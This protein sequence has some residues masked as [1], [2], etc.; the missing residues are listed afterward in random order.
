MKTWTQEM[1]PLKIVKDFGPIYTTPDSIVKIRYIEFECPEC[2][3]VFKAEP[4][5]V[6]KGTVVRCSTC[7]Y[8]KNTP[9]IDAETNTKKCTSCNLK[10]NVSMFYKNNRRANGL[11]TRCKECA[12]TYKTNWVTTSGNDIKAA[13]T[14]SRLLKRYGITSE[15][16]IRLLENQNYSC[17]ICGNTP[18]KGRA[19][20]YK[21]SV[22]HC[23][24]TGV[25]RGLLCQKCNT[26]M[27]LLGDTK[28][29]LL[30]ALKYLESV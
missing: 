13:S 26:G 19:N 7:S 11:D 23:H 3:C 6:S 12:D 4:S 14:N 25:V 5:K 20:T 27:G 10:K 28:E 21:L 17:A 29:G 2:Q 8:S 16:Y 22:D 24:T 9:R 15:E 1:L 18:E 30:K